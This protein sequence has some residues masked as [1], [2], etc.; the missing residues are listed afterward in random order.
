M[1]VAKILYNQTITIFNQFC[2]GIKVTQDHVK[3]KL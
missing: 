3:I 2:R 1:R